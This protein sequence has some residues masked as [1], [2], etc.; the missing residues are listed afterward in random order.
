MRN[1]KQKA[2]AAGEE[3]A[4]S[5]LDIESRKEMLGRWEIESREE[6]EG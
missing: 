3:V 6:P 1:R 4:R 2:G 5:T